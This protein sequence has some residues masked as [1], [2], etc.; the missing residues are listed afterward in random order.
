MLR[1]RRKGA[2]TTAGAMS[3]AVLWLEPSWRFMAL[4]E[5]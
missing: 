1:E 3:E 2:P 5:E 4:R